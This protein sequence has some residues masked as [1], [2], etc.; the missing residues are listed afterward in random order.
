MYK[1]LINCVFIY[2][3]YN[4]YDY[5]ILIELL[6]YFVFIISLTITLII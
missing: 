2:V 6:I 1:L 4:R 5:W 3:Y